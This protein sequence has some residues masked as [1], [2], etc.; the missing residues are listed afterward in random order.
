MRDKPRAV[1]VSGRSFFFWFRFFWRPPKEMNSAASADESVG[2]SLYACDE[3]QRQTL[4]LALRRAGSFLLL[5]AKRNGTKEKGQPRSKRHGALFVP[6][7]F[8][9][10]SWL[11]RKTPH[12]HV[13][14]PPGLRSNP[15]RPENQ[16]QRQRQRQ[17]NRNGKPNPSYR[18]ECPASS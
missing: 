15:E 11:G 6:G 3:K 2:S 7:F 17:R 5:D 8:D 18:S 14:R 12:I 9:S 13:R 10:P 4:P 1:D 16:D